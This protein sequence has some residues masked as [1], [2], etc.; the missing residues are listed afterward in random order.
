MV[1]FS[2]CLLAMTMEMT[3]VVPAPQDLP[4]ATADIPDMVDMAGRTLTSL[5]RPSFN[6]SPSKM[7]IS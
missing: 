5:Y 6:P 3:G 1:M 7:S 4:S 2:G